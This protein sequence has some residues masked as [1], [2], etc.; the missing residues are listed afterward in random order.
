MSIL[1]IKEALI[2]GRNILCNKKYK[3][4]KLKGI[5]ML[6]KGFQRRK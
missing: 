1:R 5:K 3:I 2:Y 6:K 4:N